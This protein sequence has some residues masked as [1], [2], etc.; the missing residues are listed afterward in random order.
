M[1]LSKFEKLFLCLSVVFFTVPFVSYLF[2]KQG[3]PIRLAVKT[4]KKRMKLTL[5][6]RTFYDPVEVSESKSI[7]IAKLRLKPDMDLVETN[8]M[9]KDF[10]NAVSTIGINLGIIE[11]TTQ[12]HKEKIIAFLRDELPKLTDHKQTLQKTLLFGRLIPIKT[13]KRL[14]KKSAKTTATVHEFMQSKYSLSLLLDQR[15]DKATDVAS[16]V[17]GDL[18]TMLG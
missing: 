1:K 16:Q 11:E 13:I 2:A 9:V 8:E 17:I 12:E 6:K 7:K 18:E 3:E 5:K 10:L 4:N 14:L 15:I